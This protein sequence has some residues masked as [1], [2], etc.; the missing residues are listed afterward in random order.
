MDEDTQCAFGATTCLCTHT[1]RHSCAHIHEKILEF[2]ENINIPLHKQFLA[3]D[4]LP[5]FRA[6][7]SS[8]L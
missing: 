6:D 7:P 2:I 4:F 8:V 5:P 1:C 3:E